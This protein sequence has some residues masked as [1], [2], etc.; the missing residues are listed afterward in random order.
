MLVS[1][2]HG[3]GVPFGLGSQTTMK[4]IEWN[5]SYEQG[6]RISLRI[7]TCCEVHERNLTFFS[8]PQYA[9]TRV[10]T[11]MGNPIALV[12]GNVQDRYGREAGTMNTWGHVFTG[13]SDR[14]RAGFFIPH[15]EL[16]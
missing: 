1:T 6:S 13:D 4:F 16:R 15:R 10:R 7:S 9:C 12:C 5:H 2:S 8:Q 14:A 11:K 3:S